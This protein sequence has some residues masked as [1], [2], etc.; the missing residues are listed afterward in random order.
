VVPIRWDR[1]SLGRP[2]VLRKSPELSGGRI[3]IQ[4]RAEKCLDKMFKFKAGLAQ[5]LGVVYWLMGV[6]GLAATQMQ[7]VQI[8]EPARVVLGSSSHALL[9]GPRR[10]PCCSNLTAPVVFL[11]QLLVFLLLPGLTPL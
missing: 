10:A 3:Y 1:H 6:H 9:A 7:Q 2:E 4:A 11:F 8:V 5:Q